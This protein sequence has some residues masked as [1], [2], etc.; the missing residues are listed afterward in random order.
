MRPPYEITTTIL[1]YVPSISEKLGEVQAKY[2][3][4]PSPQLRKQIRI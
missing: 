1:R 3:N 2:L 4:K